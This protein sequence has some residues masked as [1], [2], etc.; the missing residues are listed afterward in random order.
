MSYRKLD[1]DLLQQR[2]VLFQGRE[3]PIREKTVR[4][5]MGEVRKFR[6]GFAALISDSADKSIY[7]RRC[8]ETQIMSDTIRHFC[9]I[10][11]DVL[12]G[13]PIAAFNSLYFCVLGGGEGDV[14]DADEKRDAGEFRLGGK[15]YVVTAPS[16]RGTLDILKMIESTG[17]G[18]TEILVNIAAACVP[19][20]T[21][22]ELCEMP[23]RALSDVVNVILES[24]QG[25]DLKNAPARA[26]ITA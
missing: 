16:V 1:F 9:D 24:I 20:I 8:K 4:D 18:D 14:F 3:Y 2:K 17:E 11:E 26:E 10:N 23:Y 12:F 15:V 21:R 25:D 19:E 22:E 13:L 7:E 5:E 6:E